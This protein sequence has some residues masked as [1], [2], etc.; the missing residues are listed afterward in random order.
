MIRRGFTLIELLVVISIISVL[1]S[2]VIVSLGNA[3]EKARTAAALSMEGNLQRSWGA[4]ALGM[5][6]MREGSGSTLSNGGVG[7]AAGTIIGATWITDGPNNRPALRFSG[8]QRVT[9]G[10]NINTP[11]AVTATVWVRT[12]S[13]GTMPIFS[14][15][16]GGFF[17]GMSN[18]RVYPYNDSGSPPNMLSIRTINDNKWHFVVWSSDGSTSK[19]YID[20]VLDSQM[21]QPRPAYTSTGAYIGYDAPTNWY[22]TG[23]IGPVAVYPYA[24]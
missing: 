9:L 1:S 2:I 6:D 3:R 16:G 20:G 5:W 10:P 4:D 7:G 18:G 22:F 14:N 12:T 15:R 24:L 8:G 13:N 23:D 19:L 17:F 21:N 11:V